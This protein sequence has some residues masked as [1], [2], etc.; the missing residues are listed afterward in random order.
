M[1]DQPKPPVVSDDL[2]SWSGD[3]LAD[4]EVMEDLLVSGADW[5]STEVDDVVIQSCRLERVSLTGALLTRLQLTDVELVDCELSGTMFQRLSARRVTFRM[6]RMSGLV[7]TNAGLADVQFRDCKLDE[8]NFRM[9]KGERVAFDD[10][11]LSAADFYQAELPGG[12]FVRCDLRGAEFSKAKLAGAVL[13]G[14]ELADLRGARALAGTTISSA[15]AVPVG[16]LLLG[17]LSITVDD[18]G[19]AIGPG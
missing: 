8:S 7:M 11:V 16:L 19:D 13:H 9:T 12:R 4:E 15:Q 17:E 3:T 6:C 10:T 18:D 2:A 5:T 1:A 14:S